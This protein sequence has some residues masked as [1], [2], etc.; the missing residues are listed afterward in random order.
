MCTGDRC[1]LCDGEKVED[2][3]HLVLRCKEM[4]KRQKQRKSLNFNV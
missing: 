4:A 3:P 1:V 2:V